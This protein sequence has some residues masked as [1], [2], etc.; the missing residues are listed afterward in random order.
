M[1]EVKGKNP[2]YFVLVNED[3]RLSEGFEN[4][5]ELIPTEN[6]A[7]NQ[8]MVEK[9]TYD[10]FLNKSVKNGQLKK[11]PSYGRIEIYLP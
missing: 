3:N 11:T 8:F 2:D 4:S 5:I 9:K 6:I 1:I 7:G 10:A